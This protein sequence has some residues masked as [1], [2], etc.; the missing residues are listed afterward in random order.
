MLAASVHLN[1]LGVKLKKQIFR[2]SYNNDFKAFGAKLVA[3]FRDNLDWV[4]FRIGS[5]KGDFCF[6]CVL[7]QLVKGAGPECI[8]TNESDFKSFTDVIRGQFRTAGG[9]ATT[10]QANEHDHIDLAFYRLKWNRLDLDN[11][12]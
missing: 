6:C 4:S 5:I 12:K 2:F 11:T 3:S 7:F 8:T 9:L 1:S 10:L